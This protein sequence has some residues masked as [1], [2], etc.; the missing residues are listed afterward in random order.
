MF[1]PVI[2]PAWFLTVSLIQSNDAEL[3]QVLP[4]QIQGFEHY[5]AAE[6]L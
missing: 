6:G 1:P 5:G 3:P 4:C 2:A